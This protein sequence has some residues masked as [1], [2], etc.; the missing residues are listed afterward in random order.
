MAEWDR[1]PEETPI[2]F[3]AFVI[4]RSMPPSD[5]SLKKATEIR[6]GRKPTKRHVNQLE[7]WSGK[8]NWFDRAAAW[9]THQDKKFQRDSTHVIQRDK[10]R[11]LRQAYKMLDQGSLLLDKAEI[12]NMSAEEARKKMNIA[13]QLVTGGS[14]I[15]M[16]VMGLS[17]KQ[18]NT[19]ISAD[20]SE[21]AILINQFHQVGGFNSSAEGEVVSKDS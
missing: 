4:Y 20:E 12:H 14:K 18:Q 10:Q 5:R 1:K 7:L 15:V 13:V 6:L 19:L 3:A 21:V 8:Y 2:A 16:D 17:D 11:I 9:D